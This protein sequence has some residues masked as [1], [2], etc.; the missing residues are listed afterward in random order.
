VATRKYEASIVGLSSLGRIDRLIHH[1]VTS[2]ALNGPFEA[3][4]CLDKLDELLVGFS[5]GKM[6]PARAQAGSDL[7][8]DALT[9]IASGVVDLFAMAASS[10]RHNSSPKKNVI[11]LRSGCLSCR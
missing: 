6:D 1:Q 7:A 10:V 11:V 2:V 3:L 9:L 5:P 8:L 4:D